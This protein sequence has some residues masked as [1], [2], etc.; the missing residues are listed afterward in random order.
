MSIKTE[1]TATVYSLTV[2]HDGEVKHGGLYATAADAGNAIS[3]RRSLA[4]TVP[5]GNAVMHAVATASGFDM[6][7][8]VVIG[9]ATYIITPEPVHTVRSYI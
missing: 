4:L 6:P 3:Y 1:T 8:E 2:K 9:K 7:G 5:E